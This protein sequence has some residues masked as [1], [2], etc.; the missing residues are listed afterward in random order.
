MRPSD[1]F[2]L[3]FASET[4]TSPF[5]VGGA[6]EQI[7]AP[8]KLVVI[9]ISYLLVFGK[10]VSWFSMKKL[11]SVKVRE[12]DVKRSVKPILSSASR[13]EGK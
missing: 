3:H 1:E 6:L 4:T 11:E 8:G 2:T 12:A 13:V 9:K 7:K 5:L 10:P